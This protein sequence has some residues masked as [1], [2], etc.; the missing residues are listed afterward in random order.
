MDNE[1]IFF[2]IF[3]IW[4]FSIYGPPY[5]VFVYFK[6]IFQKTS[7]LL[8]FMK[9][10]NT[11]MASQIFTSESDSDNSEKNESE[12]EKETDENR[13]IIRYEDKYLVE[14]RKMDSGQNFDEIEQKLKDEKYTEFLNEMKETYTNKID[15]LKTIIETNKSKLEKYEGSEDEYC[16]YD[17][18]DEDANLGETKEQRVKTLNDENNKLYDEINQ[19][20]KQI[21][22]KEGQEEIFKSVEEKT[23]K[24]MIEQ[25]IERLKN[26]YVMEYTPLGNVLMMY[27]KKRES[28]KFYSDNTIPYR[29]LEVVGRKYAKQ[30]GVKQ[31]FIDMEEELK[32]AEE[33]WERERKEKDEQEEEERIK[34]EEAIK[35][36]KQVEQKKSV[37]A[38][39]KSYNKDAGSGHVNIGAPPKNSIPNK[40][41]TE[42]Q[43]N[44]KILLK[45]KANR[46]TYEGKLVNFSF[47]KKIDRKDVNKKYAMTFAD[48]KKMQLMKNNS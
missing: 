17:R 33:R 39:F 30:F 14:F 26:C 32:L 3:I 31:I 47:T 6:N 24:F 5:T 21:N 45:E 35:N 19:L 22:T 4:Y 44:E 13:S 20:M 34:K 1:S 11:L 25:R 40:K 9:H 41:L 48:F 29:Y 15:E 42:K 38:K 28:F 16:I 18:S 10:F 27:D 7:D 2:T 43:E 37:F 36:N 8:N 46:Y 23:N 12:S